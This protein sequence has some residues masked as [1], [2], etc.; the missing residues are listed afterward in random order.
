MDKTY[1]LDVAIKAS[2]RAGKAI[3]KI[4]EEDDEIVFNQKLDNSPITKADIASNTEILKFLQRTNIPII[5]EENKNLS[6]DARG[7]WETCWVVDPL[8]GTKEFIKRNGEF[9][10]NIALVSNNTPILGVIYVPVTKELFFSDSEEAKA[11]K[12]TLDVN[13]EFSGQMMSKT[14]EITPRKRIENTI[15]IVGS[16][17]HMNKETEEFVTKLSTTY[18]NVEIVSKGSSLK[19]CLVAEGKADVYP[20]FAPTMEWD[21]AAGQAICN[22]VGIKV[23]SKETGEPLLYNKENLLNSHFIVRR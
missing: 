23:I 6:Y 21:T 2:I 3:L 13:H 16:R 10:V 20:R 15:K 5:S 18:S 7:K 12:V 19:F 11:Y 4:Y 14:N 8:D 17:S 9:T 22:A 1:L